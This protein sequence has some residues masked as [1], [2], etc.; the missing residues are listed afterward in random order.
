MNEN[1]TTVMEVMSTGMLEPTLVRTNPVAFLH[2]L[3]IAAAEGRHFVVLEDTEGRTVL[4]EVRNITRVRELRPGA[5][6]APYI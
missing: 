2:N 6:D 1:E 4:L 3:N 5:L